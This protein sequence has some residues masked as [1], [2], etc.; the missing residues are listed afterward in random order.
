[1]DMSSTQISHMVFRR[2]SPVNRG[3]FSLEGQ[4]LSVLM[5]LDGTKT[6]AAVAK[7]LGLNIAAMREVVSRLLQLGLIEQTD[8]AVSK[9]DQEFMAY[10]SS[11][12]AIAVGPIASILIED[13][14]R[15]LGQTLLH[16]PSHRA[17][18]LV[19]I[20]AREIQREEKRVAFKQNMVMKI[21]EKGY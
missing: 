21:N 20:L 7:D 2:I 11:Q 19:D 9:V 8:D 6:L 15:D 13:A 5:E 10:L 12:L 3:T 16:F 4:T 18:E 1:M 17:A 14:A